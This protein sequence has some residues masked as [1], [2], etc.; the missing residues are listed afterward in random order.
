MTNTT[1]HGPYTLFDVGVNVCSLAGHT[2]VA[3][4]LI[5]KG[6][7]GPQSVIQLCALHSR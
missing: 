5:E 7:Q 1:C 6:R 3:V 4:V 2:S